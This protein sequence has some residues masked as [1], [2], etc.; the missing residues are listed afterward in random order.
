[1]TD[2]DID[3]IIKEGCLNF[4]QVSHSPLGIEDSLPRRRRLSSGN[5]N[6]LGKHQ[7]AQ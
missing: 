4:L 5:G 2:D 1:M 6:R 3:I 7:F